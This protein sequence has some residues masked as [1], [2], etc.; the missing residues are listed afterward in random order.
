M[1]ELIAIFCVVTLYG[2]FVSHKEIP[3]PD[4]FKGFRIDGDNCMRMGMAV[5]H[6]CVMKGFDHAVILDHTTSDPEKYYQDL[7]PTTCG[8]LVTIGGQPPTW[9]VTAYT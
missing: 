4:T 5:Y 1:M 8:L 2:P 7:D 6:Q 3:I 9:N